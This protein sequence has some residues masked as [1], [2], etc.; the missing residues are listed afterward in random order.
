[1]FRVRVGLCAS[2]SVGLGEYGVIKFYQVCAKYVFN[3]RRNNDRSGRSGLFQHEM[4]KKAII[5]VL[6]MNRTA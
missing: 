5:R 6:S 1:M 2:K 4:Q 3:V